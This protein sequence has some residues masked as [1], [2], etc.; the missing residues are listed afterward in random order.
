MQS[1]FRIP[2]FL[3]NGLIDG[4]EFLS[5]KRRSRYNPREGSGTHFYWRP[6]QPQGHS[7]AGR[8]R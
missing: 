2:H 6:S 8:I 1:T 5:V 4:G 7:V 3:D